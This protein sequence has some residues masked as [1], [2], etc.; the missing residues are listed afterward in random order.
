MW[1]S[2]ALWNS[3]KTGVFRGSLRDDRARN[4]STSSICC[5]EQAENVIVHSSQLHNYNDM[6]YWCPHH[7]AQYQ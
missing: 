5:R 3:T 4:G 2:G 6:V 7:T 1:E